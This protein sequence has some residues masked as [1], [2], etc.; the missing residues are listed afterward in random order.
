MVFHA[1]HKKQNDGQRLDKDMNK[2]I[3]QG[4]ETHTMLSELS[5]QVS[6]GFKA[7]QSRMVAPPVAFPPDPPEAIQTTAAN[8]TEAT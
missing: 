6:D 1:Q 8:A 5:K 7:T 4:S 2:I 3:K